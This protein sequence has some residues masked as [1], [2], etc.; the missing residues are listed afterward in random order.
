MDR[1]GV[2][3]A[4]TGDEDVGLHQGGKVV[5]VP[6]S[7]RGFANARR[8]AT[9]LRRREENGPDEIEIAL[10]AHALHQHGADHAAPADESYDFGGAH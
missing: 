8:R 1:R 4:L 3:A 9:E 7:R 5:S 2:F 10:V 6:D